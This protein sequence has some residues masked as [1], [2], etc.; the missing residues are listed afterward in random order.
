[1][2]GW[3]RSFRIQHILMRENRAHLLKKTVTVKEKNRLR[4]QLIDLEDD[5]PV[6]PDFFQLWK[7]NRDGEKLVS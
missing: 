2:C 5:F 4:K 1:M 3:S 7:N 6:I